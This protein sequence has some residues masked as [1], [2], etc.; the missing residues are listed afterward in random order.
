[1]DLRVVLSV[2]DISH[3]RCGRP[4]VP[5]KHSASARSIA[6]ASS[7]HKLMED[8]GFK[9]AVLV[10][11]ESMPVVL[12]TDETEEILSMRILWTS[13]SCIRCGCYLSFSRARDALFYFDQAAKVLSGSRILQL[14]RPGPWIR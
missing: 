1:M 6:H 7:K 10:L 2:S 9:H 11:E 4:N 3:Y 5:T 13:P 12:P 8:L 14:S